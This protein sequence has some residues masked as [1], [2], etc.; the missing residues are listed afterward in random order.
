[1]CAC[2]CKLILKMCE[3][4]PK[5][6]I[7]E[8]QIRCTREV[9]LLSRTRI[10]A[11]KE[12]KR[13]RVIE[14]IYLPHAKTKEFRFMVLSVLL[15]FLHWA[16]ARR[17][18]PMTRVTSCC[19]G[20]LLSQYSCFVQWEREWER[21][22]KCERESGREI[23]G[24]CIAEREALLVALSLGPL[25]HIRECVH[26]YVYAYIWI[27]LHACVC[28]CCVC[29]PCELRS[30]PQSRYCSAKASIGQRL[31]KPNHIL[32]L[33]QRVN[34][35]CRRTRNTQ[36]HKNRKSQCTLSWFVMI[37]QSRA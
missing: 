31:A 11:Q 25:T 30:S 26:T 7:K 17:I 3:A 20:T 22:S 14:R 33:S 9:Q 1:M 21:A 19:D 23:E 27:Y 15:F 12:R 34:N 28:V 18:R 5:E 2:V 29:Y 36:T 4:R 32:L 13:E 37:E 24:G 6:E 16:C 10:T 35:S 8:N